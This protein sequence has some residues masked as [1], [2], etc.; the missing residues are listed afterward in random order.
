M[1]YDPD[2]R[3]FT[4]R[5]RPRGNAASVVMLPRHT[6]GKSGACPR[7]HGASW[8]IRKDR[9]LVK[10]HRRARLVVLTLRPGHCGASG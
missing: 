3:T 9:L 4:L 10:R 8:R 6:Y 5:Y 7:T 1:T 2:R